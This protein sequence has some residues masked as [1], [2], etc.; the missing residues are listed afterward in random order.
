MKQSTVM[1]SCSLACSIAIVHAHNKTA[2]VA[3][4]FIRNRGGDDMTEFSTGIE[5][6]EI[7]SVV[8]GDMT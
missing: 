8:T 5:N 3:V 6:G 2:H 7:N 4:L 1:K